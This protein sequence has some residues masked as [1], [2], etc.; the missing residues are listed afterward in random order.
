MRRRPAPQNWT[1]ADTLPFRQAHRREC[2]AHVER[3]LAGETLAREWT[4]AQI[5]AGKFH[6]HPDHLVDTHLHCEPTGWTQGPLTLRPQPGLAFPGRLD[7]PLLQILAALQAGQ[8]LGETLAHCAV[9]NGTAPAADLAPPALGAVRK[10][11]RAG[12]L[13]TSPALANANVPSDNPPA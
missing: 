4:D 6:L 8:P 13:T 5:L 11:L 12:L 7:G 3:V 9:Q 2:G 1:R 10:L